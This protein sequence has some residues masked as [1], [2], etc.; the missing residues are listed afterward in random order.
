MKKKYIGL[1]AALILTVCLSTGVMMAWLIDSTE[2][3]KNTFTISTIDVNIKETTGE[4]YKMVPGHTIKK[5]SLVSVNAGSEPCY[6]FIKLE[7]SAN[8]KNFMTYTPADGWI[9]LSTSD[10]ED[11][12][13]REVTNLQDPKAV[14]AAKAEFDVL[15]DDE[16]RVLPDVTKEDMTSASFTEPTLD[17]SVHGVQL[18]SDNNTKFEPSDAW[19]LV[20]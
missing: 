17:I 1:G 11:V 19:D 14:L 5:D 18:Y 2:P 9:P 6:I 8:F 12:Y 10:T 16:I 15:K 20:E 13:Y 7:K 4:Q 3:I